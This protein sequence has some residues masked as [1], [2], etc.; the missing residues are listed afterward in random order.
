MPSFHFF[1]HRSPRLVRRAG[2]VL[3]AEASGDIVY[4]GRREESGGTK[5]HSVPSRLNCELHTWLPRSRVANTFGQ[6]DL[7]L[8]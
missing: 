7:P 2:L 1:I 8:A 4:L 5:E 3:Q 6:D